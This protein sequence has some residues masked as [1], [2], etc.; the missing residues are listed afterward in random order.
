[1]LLKFVCVTDT[2]CV[3]TDP[4][5]VAFAVKYAQPAPLLA[6]MRN[7]VTPETSAMRLR[8]SQERHGSA[9]W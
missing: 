9:A 8:A 6:A 3:A 7:A 1:M 2:A 4:V 5:A